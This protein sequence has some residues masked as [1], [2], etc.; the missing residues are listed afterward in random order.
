MMALFIVLWLLSSSEQVKKAVGDIPVIPPTLARMSG[1]T[2][3]GSGS[4]A[5]S[6]QG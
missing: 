2:L 6:P 1:N 4:K 3:K 5:E